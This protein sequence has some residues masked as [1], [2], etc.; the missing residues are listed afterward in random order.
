MRSLLVHSSCL[1]TTAFAMFLQRESNSRASSLHQQAEMVALAL[2][3]RYF[4][5]YSYKRVLN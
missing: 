3:L 2:K 5:V 4:I 1:A